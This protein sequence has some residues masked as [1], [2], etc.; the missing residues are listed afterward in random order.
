MEEEACATYHS[1]ISSLKDSITSVAAR[2]KSA[3]VVAAC[4][5]FRGRVEAVVAQGGGH[6][7]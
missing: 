2:I 6:I 5:S 1:N 7:E 3:E 4:S